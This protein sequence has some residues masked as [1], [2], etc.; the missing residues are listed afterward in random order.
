MSRKR[1]ERIPHA[2]GA[3]LRPLAVLDEEDGETRY[4]CSRGRCPHWKGQ[5]PIPGLPEDLRGMVCSVVNADPGAGCFPYYLE[6]AEKLDR[7]KRD[8]W[9]RLDEAERA[10]RGIRRAAE[11]MTA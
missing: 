8:I 7:A 10:E 2:S 6:G 5:P 3:T 11:A 1:T 4:L 9:A